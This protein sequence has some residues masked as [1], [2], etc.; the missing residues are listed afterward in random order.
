MCQLC[1]QDDTQY[2]NA[3][4]ACVRHAELLE[5]MARVERGLASGRIKPHDAN[6][7]AGMIARSLIRYLVEEWL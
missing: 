1:S 2:K 3:T 6:S 7:E 5:K 4:M